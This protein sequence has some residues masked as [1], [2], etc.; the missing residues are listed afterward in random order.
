MIRTLIS[1]KTRIKLLYKF[2]LNQQNK[3][4]L[5]SLESELGGS[6][7]AIRIELNRLESGGLLETSTSGN[8]KYYQANTSHPL[9]HEINH[10]LQKTVGTDK[11]CRAIGKMEE[12]QSVYLT[13]DLAKGTESSLIDLILCGNK[14]NQGQVS[15]ILGKLEK[16]LKKSIRFQTFTKE[17]TERFVQKNISYKIYDKH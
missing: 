10:M 3:G 11:I 8:K 9:F 4:Y 13:G 6:T 17:Q 5:R 16:Q 15:N 1:N 14:I 7:N 2:F 12:I